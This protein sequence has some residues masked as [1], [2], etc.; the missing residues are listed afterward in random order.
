[1]YTW[2]NQPYESMWNHLRFLQAPKNVES[3]LTGKMRSSRGLVLPE[4]EL[5]ERKSRQIAYSI[6]QADEYFQSAQNVSIAT[7]PLLYFYG[8][9]SLAKATV[10]AN[11]PNL[12]LGDIKYHGLFT[13]P[14]TNELKDYVEDHHQWSVDKEFAVTNDGV[15]DELFKVVCGSS[16]PKNSVIKLK[17][18]FKINPEIG[19]IYSRFYSEPPGFFPLYGH[20]STKEP[21][22]IEINPQTTDKELFLKSFGFIQSDFEVLDDILHSQALRVVSKPSLQTIPEY[23]HIYYAIPGGR[24]LVSGLEIENDG[25]SQ[26]LYVPQELCDYIAMFILGDIVRYKQEFWGQVIS[27][28]KD[29]SISLVNLFV[30]I[31]KNR[32]P[33]FILNQI[34]NETFTYGSVGRMM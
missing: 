4:G 26:R 19:D 10:V 30:S 13:R 29:G 12:L 11:D 31:A 20:K 8:M 7:S 25:E 23:M 1:M 3:L 16:L 27:G 32:F 9:L 15:V 21:F 22:H 5:A 17:E 18:L 33:N 24:Y 14:I 28:E 34:F 6:K 2:T